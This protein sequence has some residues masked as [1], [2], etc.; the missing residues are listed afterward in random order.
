MKKPNAILITAALAMGLSSVAHAAAPL[1][2]VAKYMMPEAVK[3]SFDHLAA[4]VPSDR[5]LVTAESAHEVLVFNL[6]T[7]KYLQA[8]TGIGVPHAIFFR[9]DLNRI[10]ITDGG[11]GELRIYNGKTYRQIGAVKLKVD[12]DSIGYDH[13]THNLYIVNGGGEAHEPFSMLSVVNTTDDR[14]VAEIK[15]D[16]DTL[17][18]MALAPSGALLY[19]DN[20]SK[21]QVDVVNRQTRS[22][23]KTWPVTMGKKNVAMAF[24]SSTHRLFVACRS[25]NLVIFDTQTGKE[26]QSLPIG[27]GV[28]DLIFDPA[29]K[30]LY[31]ACGSGTIAVYREDGPNHYTSLGEVAS[32]PRG[33][34]EILVPKLQRLFMTIPPRGSTPGQVYVY[35]VQ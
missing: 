9:D 31:V 24:D 26:V 34:N 14:K 11:A 33:K 27:T 7:G 16:G 6:R 23:I 28:D 21:N 32:A 29:T 3:G 18:A 30:R 1:K 13:V 17:E 12:S 8:I 10:Y 25:G 15:I 5:L 19:I 20:P 22:V 35:Q 4:D 2:L